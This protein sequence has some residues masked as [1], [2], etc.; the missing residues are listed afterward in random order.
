MRVKGG[1]TTNRRHKRLREKVEGFVGSRR[2][3]YKVAKTTFDR[4]LVFAYRDRRA[5][6]R[7][8]RALWITRINAAIR[9]FDMSYS[10]FIS[11]LKKANIMLDRKTLAELAV[12]DIK[13]F[14]AVVKAAKQAL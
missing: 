5:Y 3:V 1:K 10:K 6:R 8:I 11:A 9:Q 4:S 12:S 7:E 2:R 14:E 13:A